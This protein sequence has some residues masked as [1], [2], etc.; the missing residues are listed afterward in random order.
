[1]DAGEQTIDILL[2]EERRY[3]PP[4]EFAAQANAQPDIYEREFDEFWEAQRS[5]AG[6]LVRAVH[7]ALRVGARRTRSGTWAASSTSPTTAST[8]T[9][10]RGTATRSPTTGRVSRRT[11]GSSSPTPSCSGWWCASR[12]RS[13]SSASRKGT[14]VAIYMGMVP[15][16]P[17]GDARVHAAGRAA[18]RR[19]RRLLGRLA[20]GPDERHG[21]RGARHP[22]RGLAPRRPGAAEED[23]RRGDGRWRPV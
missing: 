7:V 4:P 23:R 21:L 19:V 14:P 17:G 12:T 8:A 6:D 5:R 11:T 10:R 18:H 15:E 9:S 13:R 2:D 1:M 16:L 20:L 3:P 22:G